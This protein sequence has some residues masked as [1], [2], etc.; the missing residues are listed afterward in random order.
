MTAPAETKRAS[1][2]IEARAEIVTGVSNN[3]YHGLKT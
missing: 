1:V 2:R 3:D